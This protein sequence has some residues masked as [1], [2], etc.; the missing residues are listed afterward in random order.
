MAAMRELPAPP[1]PSAPPAPTAASRAQAADSA[2]WP[3]AR[4]MAPPPPPAA[5]KAS[6]AEPAAPA[7]EA[8][9][10][11][12]EADIPPATADAP[13]VREAW[14]RR[15]GELQREGRTAEARASL[16]EFRRRYPEAELPAELR[17]LE[18]P[19]AQPASH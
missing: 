1:A 18:T 7:L 11:A 14:L 9:A 2:A 4:M 15:I 16:A 6:A 12:P 19:P 10:D 8:L 3:A 17:A 13:A 5:A